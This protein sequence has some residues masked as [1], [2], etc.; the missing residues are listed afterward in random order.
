MT[1]NLKKAQEVIDKCW[2][3]AKALNN[4]GQCW[5][6]MKFEIRNLAILVSKKNL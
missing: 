3:Q 1:K 2:K 6:L 5:E 4:F